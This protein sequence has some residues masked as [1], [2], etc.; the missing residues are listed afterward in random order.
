MWAV[1]P[2]GPQQASE[3]GD[4]GPPRPG[5]RRPQPRAEVD[6]GPLRPARPT[7]R[8]A[9][10]AEARIA[11]PRFR[12]NETLISSTPTFRSLPR[13]ALLDYD[14]R[15]QLLFASEPPVARPIG[16]NPAAAPVSH[17]NVKK[18]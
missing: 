3:V 6:P 16:R 2:S 11:S 15:P 12:S 18:V 1:E 8:P 9:P 14:R 4:V 13:Q 17:H 10:V 7:L 5:R